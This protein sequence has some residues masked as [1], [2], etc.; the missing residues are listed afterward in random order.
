MG[1]STIEQKNWHDGNYIFVTMVVFKKKIWGIFTNRV[2]LF[3]QKTQGLCFCYIPNIKF[4]WN[5][6]N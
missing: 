6:F 4:K 2:P 3:R 1:Q 5:K